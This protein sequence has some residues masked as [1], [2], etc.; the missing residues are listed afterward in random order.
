MS[1]FLHVQI[2]VKRQLWAISLLF[3]AAG[4]AVAA[5]DYF[6]AK[7]KFDSIENGRLHPGAHVTLS[8]PEL[9][10][11]VEKEAP[12]GV[13]S[14]NLRVTERDLAT[15]T[16]LIDFAKLERS[17]GQRPGWLM[18]K[19][20]EGE[21]PVSVTARIR[22][23]NGHATVDLQRVEISGV[24]IDGRTLDF[25]VQN[26]LLALYPDAVIGKPFE[27]GHRIDRL[28]VAPAAVGVVI[29]R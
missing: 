8:Y 6:S 29:G 12:R 11:W 10:A 9:T 22:S 26:F 14:P 17:Q 2:N 19:L 13:R 25:L 5:G 15:G 28:D 24:T 3:V 1:Q 23:A 20:L 16:A 4:L 7:Q 18:S 21:R 27:L